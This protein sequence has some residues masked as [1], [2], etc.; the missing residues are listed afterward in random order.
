MVEAHFETAAQA[1]LRCR[2]MDGSLAER[3][4]AFTQAARKLGPALQ[5]AADRMVARLRASGAGKDAPKVG[6]PMPPFMLPDEAG[7]LVSLDG[8]LAQGP[9][10]ITFHRGHWCP[11]CRISMKALAEAQKKID[12]PAQ[13]VAVMPDRQEF[14]AEFKSQ[15]PS[16]IPILTDMDN[17]YAMSL[18]L[19][20]W[21]GE[22]MVREMKRVGADPS[23]SQGQD[24]WMLPIPATFVVGR[25]GH[26]RAR[27]VDP[28]YRKRMAIDDLLAALKAAD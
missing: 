4:A 15:A 16:T 2:D 7:R 13:I 26:V 12:G 21:V 11:F 6:D 1:F 5:D 28:D 18:N 17:G 24:P 23:T 19:A 20:I 14:A 3:L 9:A 22:E 25:D 27:F 8:L 10:A